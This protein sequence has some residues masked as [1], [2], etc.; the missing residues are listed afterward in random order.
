VTSSL[1]IARAWSSVDALDISEFSQSALSE[2]SAKQ[3][4]TRGDSVVVA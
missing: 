4:S 3:P 1:T 2:F